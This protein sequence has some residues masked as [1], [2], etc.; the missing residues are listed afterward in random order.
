[1]ADHRDSGSL[2]AGEARELRREGSAV[3]VL[4]LDFDDPAAAGGRRQAQVYL[5][6]WRS[7]E[8]TFETKINALVPGLLAWEE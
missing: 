3:Y 5:C 6:R 1:M 2:R 4:S 8:W 7:T